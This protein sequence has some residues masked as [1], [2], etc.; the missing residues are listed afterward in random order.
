MFSFLYYPGSPVDQTKWLVFRMI[1]GS[2]IP[3][4]TKGQSLVDLNFLGIWMSNKSNGMSFYKG[5]CCAGRFWDC[6]GCCSLSVVHEK[7]SS[8]KGPH[9]LGEMKRI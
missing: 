9:S 8:Q 7:S 6:K 5:L 4:P 3:D 1:H 2:R